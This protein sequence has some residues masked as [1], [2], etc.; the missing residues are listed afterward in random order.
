MSQHHAHVRWDRGERPFTY[1]TYSRDHDIRFGAAGDGEALRA[2]AAE[3]YGGTAALPNPEEQLVAALSTCHML[4]FLAIAA[5]RGIG[6]DRYEDH[7]EGTLGKNAEGRLA[8]TR[9]ILRPTVAFSSDAHVDALLL[10]TLHQG[11]HR[12]CFIAAS[13]KTEISVETPQSVS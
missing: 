7:A 8:V 2:S 1:D 6:V 9:V 13:V 10:A 11:A 4:T 5:R 12:G 3:E